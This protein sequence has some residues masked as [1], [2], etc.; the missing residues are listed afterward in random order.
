MYYTGQHTVQK[1]ADTFSGSR[2]TNYR[3]L[4]DAGCSPPPRAVP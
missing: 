4:C 3:H 1:I 2:P